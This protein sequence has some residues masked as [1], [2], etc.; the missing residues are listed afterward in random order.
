[1]H[2]PLPVDVHVVQGLHSTSPVIV[3]FL[4]Y[5]PFTLYTCKLPVCRGH[6]KAHQRPLDWAF[7]ACPAHGSGR[8]GLSN[9][10]KPPGAPQALLLRPFLAVSSLTLRTASL[11]DE[12]RGAATVARRGL[13]SARLGH[14]SSGSGRTPVSRRR[15]GNALTAAARSSV[16]G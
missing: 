9:G 7:T 8:L 15:A 1:M 13:L 2:L 6:L 4:N 5:Y 10:G 11:L 16:S 14:V 12:A 3:L